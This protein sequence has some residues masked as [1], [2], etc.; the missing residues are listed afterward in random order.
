MKRNLAAIGMLLSALTAMAQL[1]IDF[2][3]EQIYL[4]PR[5]THC[6]PG[7]TLRVEGVVTCIARGRVAPYSRYLYVELID[8]GNVVLSR[9]K[10]ACHDRGHFRIDFPISETQSEGRY[11]LRGYTQLMRNFNPSSFAQEPVTISYRKPKHAGSRFDEICAVTADGNNLLAGVPQVVTAVLRDGELN[12]VSGRYMTLTDSLGNVVASAITSLSGYAQFSF[13]PMESMRYDVISD[14]V[15]DAC[16]YTVGYA[17]GDAVKLSCVLHGKRLDFSIDGA[18]LPVD[19][20]NLY[21]YD[22]QNGL[23]HIDTQGRDG[24]VEFAVDPSVV[25]MFLTDADHNIVAERTVLQQSVPEA[26]DLAIML[27][28]TLSLS[29][30]IGDMLREYG[31]DSCVV[32]QRIVPYDNAPVTSALESLCYRSDFDSPL[33]FPTAA[34]GESAADSRSDIQ[35]WLGSARFKRFNLREVAENDTSIYH[36]MP[37]MELAISGKAV[38]RKRFP[39]KDGVVVAYNNTDYRVYDVPVSGEGR[40]NIPV[41]DF[42]EGTQFFIQY[43]NSKDK[44]E[45][46]ELSIPDQTYPP[47]YIDSR[48]RGTEKVLRRSG[49]AL[50]DSVDR[51]YRL[52]D[53]TVKARAQ[54]D[55]PEDTKSFY[56]VKFKD[57]SMIEQ[58]RFLTLLDV[59]KDMPVIEIFKGKEFDDS[60]IGNPGSANSYNSTVPHINPSGSVSAYKWII[61][62]RRGSSLMGQALG[63]TDNNTKSKGY[64]NVAM[65]IDGTKYDDDMLDLVLSMSTEDI[66]SVEYLSPGEAL[67]YSSF[68]IYGAIKVTTRSTYKPEKKRSKGM[69]LRPVGIAGESMAWSEAAPETPGHYRLLMDVIGPDGVKSLQHSFVV[70]E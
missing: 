50:S 62:N 1:P 45:W 38:R 53:V 13:I 23:S 59:L 69:I 54:M 33:P 9:Q 65:L 61:R 14:T 2:R 12:P 4:A 47:V 34:I 29:T 27:P 44:P 19:G 11:Y 16:I 40:F 43:V 3:S 24:T 57:R 64:T 39:V 49:I 21:V 68:A 52:P 30:P 60:D 51:S 15:A 63:S 10:V 18:S 31:G 6:I 26:G 41:D 5:S 56:G 35:A 42:A 70:A 32:I 20:R 46:V 58:R 17:A 28:D 66:E 37:E 55:Q 22:R 48:L 7:D 25:T 8:D 36:F 67:G